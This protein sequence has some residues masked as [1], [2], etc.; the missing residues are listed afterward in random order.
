MVVD[1]TPGSI[2]EAMLRM[3]SE[4]KLREGASGR[5]LQRY[6]RLHSP[7]SYLRSYLEIGRKVA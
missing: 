4:P 1:T 6:E 3:E 2:G 7:E 5:A